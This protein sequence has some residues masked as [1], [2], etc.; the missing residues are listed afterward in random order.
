[1]SNRYFIEN[2]GFALVVIDREAQKKEKNAMDYFTK[3]IKLQIRGKQIAHDE[4]VLPAG[5]E[6]FCK[7][8]I[9]FLIGNENDKEESN[10][11]VK[12][13]ADIYTLTNRV[14]ELTVVVNAILETI[15]MEES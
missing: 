8:Y 13:I 2:R 6:D 1:M 9:D 5:A 14:N 12:L 15:L 11:L 4:W 3:S 10:Q 7:S